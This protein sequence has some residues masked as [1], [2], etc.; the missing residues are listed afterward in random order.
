MPL[1][2]SV[3]LPICLNS[4]EHNFLLE[5]K[6]HLQVKNELNI[7]V[8]LKGFM[9]ISFILYVIFT[10]YWIRLEHHGK[11]YGLEQL[12]LSSMELFESAYLLS[13]ICNKYNL[14]S[15]L[16]TDVWTK[17]KWIGIGIIVNIHR[18]LIISDYRRRRRELIGYNLRGTSLTN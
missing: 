17:M 6:E 15:K 11:P 2:T 7:I 10:V 5:L 16:T 12:F 4:N 9:K 1:V 14:W 13:L 3:S 8:Q 18:Y